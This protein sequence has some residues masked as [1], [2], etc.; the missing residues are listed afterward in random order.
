MQSFFFTPFERSILVKLYFFEA[1]IW[2]FDRLLAAL[3]LP[4]PPRR[5]HT[6]TDD[7]HSLKDG[8]HPLSPQHRHGNDGGTSHVRN[9][10]NGLG[11]SEEGEGVSRSFASGSRRGGAELIWVVAGQV[12]IEDAYAG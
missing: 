12:G 4:P 6:R 5:T 10:R 9:H 3:A 7:Q 1:D 2:L 8:L 11:T